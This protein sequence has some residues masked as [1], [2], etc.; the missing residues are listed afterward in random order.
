MLVFFYAFLLLAVLLEGT[1][2]L[3]LRKWGLERGAGGGRWAFF[4][5]SLTV[6]MGGAVCWGLSLQYREVSRAIVGFAVLNVLAVAAAGVLLY[7]EELSLVNRLGILLGFCS[8]VL[9]EL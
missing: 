1:A 7:G 2:D 5:L 8:L 9:V 4:A 3:L 6:Y